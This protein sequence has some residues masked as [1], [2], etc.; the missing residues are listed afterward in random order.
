MGRKICHICGLQGTMSCPLL[1]TMLYTML[2]NQLFSFI[3]TCNTS[4]ILNPFWIEQVLFS[5]HF[6]VWKTEKFI[7]QIWL[8][9]AF[10]T[11]WTRS[12][13]VMGIEDKKVSRE[14]FWRQSLTLWTY[15]LWTTEIQQQWKTQTSYMYVT[16]ICTLLLSSDSFFAKP[17]CSNAICRQ[18]FLF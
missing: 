10:N 1:S 15:H 2:S 3:P 11:L 17:L 16:W 6:N 14:P 5:A 8:H 12:Y 18:I 4:T 9:R 7:I 13:G